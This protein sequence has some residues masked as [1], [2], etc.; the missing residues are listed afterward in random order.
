MNPIPKPL[1][2]YPRVIN[3]IL[4][5]LCQHFYKLMAYFSKNIVAQG[6]F[7]RLLVFGAPKKSFIRGFW[8]WW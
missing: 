1:D 6:P 4:D 8:P 3:G 7:A 2:G 5:K